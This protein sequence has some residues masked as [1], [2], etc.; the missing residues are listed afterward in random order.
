MTRF[1]SDK[2]KQI[3]HDKQVFYKSQMSTDCIIDFEV[4]HG[5]TNEVFNKWCKVVIQY[6][7]LMML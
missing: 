3:I 2:E 6:L 7:H 5:L 4:A 1:V